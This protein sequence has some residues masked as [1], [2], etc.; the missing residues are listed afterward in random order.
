M[1]PEQL[2]AHLTTSLKDVEDILHANVGDELFSAAT[3]RA[4]TEYIEA[5]VE[6]MDG[7]DYKSL[8]H[9]LICHLAVT[10]YS[11]KAQIIVME[12]QLEGVVKEMQSLQHLLKEAN[13]L[14]IKEILKQK[15]KN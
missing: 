5:K 12:S 8:L 7:T 10:N 6:T 13:Q 4:I 2:H 9:L 14:K 11:N 15:H 1:N 3:F